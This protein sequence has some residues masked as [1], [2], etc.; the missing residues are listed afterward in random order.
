M[1]RS[2]LEALAEYWVPGEGPVA[3]HPLAAGLVNETYR[4][5]RAGRAYSLRVPAAD[6]VDLGLD[7]RW[8]C[9]VRERAGAAGIAPAVR[10]CDPMQGVLVA[11]WVMGKFWSAPES[12]LPGNIDAMARLLR[13]VHA[14]EIPRPA[15]CMDAGKWIAHYRDALERNGGQRGAEATWQ[16]PPRGDPARGAPTVGAPLPSSGL[17]EAAAVHLAATVGIPS[18]TAGVLCHSDLHRFNL[19][20]GNRT[21]LLDWEYAH[22]SDAMWDLAGWVANNDWTTAQAE[23]LL[24]AYLG[25]PA[26]APELERLGSWVWLYDYVCLLWSEL[27]LRRRPGPA[28]G[29]VAAR[30][31]LIA[32]RLRRAAC[33]GGGTA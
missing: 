20:T 26:R 28:S 2:R 14:L 5:T 10:R 22:V 17:C 19:L 8:E 18:P 9:A 16:A 24:T 4:V 33:S 21:V 15:R 27:Y 1:P 6:C 13:Q 32:D 12:G 7:R 11:D 30:C 31:A 29:E 3:V 25:R 23:H